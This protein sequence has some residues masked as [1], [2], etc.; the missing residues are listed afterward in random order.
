[1]GLFSSSSSKSNQ[2]N[3][4]ITSISSRQE[5]ANAN[6]QDSDGSVVL[7]S[8]A[9]Y[10]TIDAGTVDL[11]EKTSIAAIDAAKTIFSDGVSVV[12]NVSTDAINKAVDLGSRALNL[13]DSLVSK[14]MQSAEKASMAALDFASNYS[15]SDQALQVESIV[16]LA[17]LGILASAIIAIAVKRGKK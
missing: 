2:T 5:T 7:G 17:G 1:M 9:Y 10:R 14:Q 11:A 6:V 12:Q 15:K 8:N 4:T 13:S 3:N 16:K